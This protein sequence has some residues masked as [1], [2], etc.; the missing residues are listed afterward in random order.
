MLEALVS[1]IDGNTD[2]SNL[3]HGQGQFHLTSLPTI[4]VFFME[5]H[6][7][8]FL[9]TIDVSIRD[10]YFIQNWSKKDEKYLKN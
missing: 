10:L 3:G 7:S 4:I 8:G 6:G 2:G 9:C 5:D 1:C